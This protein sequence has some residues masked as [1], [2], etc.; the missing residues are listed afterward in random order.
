MTAAVAELPGLAGLRDD[1]LAERHECGD[2]ATREAILAE[3]ERRDAREDRARQA[4]QRHIAQRQDWESAAY[5]Q[6]RR[7]EDHCRGYLLSEA[8]RRRGREPWPML[9][10]GGEAE[11]R[12]L[13]SEE[14]VTF[15]D[16]HEPRV[17]GPAVF[18]AARREA[19]ERP[20][21]DRPAEPIPAVAAGSASRPEPASPPP[22][23]SAAALREALAA[24]QARRA[25]VLADARARAEAVNAA[26]PVPAALARP[27]TVA[28]PPGGE[29]VPVCKGIDGTELLGYVRA[30]LARYAVFPSEPALDAVTLWAAHAHAR[31]PQGK[32]VFE[33][34]G[35][36]MFLSAD[37]DSGKSRAL[38]LVSLLTGSRFGLLAEPT[39]AAV[40]GIVGEHAEVAYLD[41]S[42]LLFGSGARR[43]TIRSLLNAG[44]QRDGHMPLV[45]GGKVHPRPV[46]GPVALAGLDAMETGTGDRLR[47]LFTRSVVI[48]MRP[49]EERVPPVDTAG[50]N[51]ASLLHQA[52]TA[53]CAAVRNRLTDARPDLPGHLLNRSIDIWL[54]L[55]AIGDAAGGEWPER[56]RR[57]RARQLRQ[58]LV[59]GQHP[60]RRQIAARQRRRPLVLGPP[61][62]PR[63]PQRPLLARARRGRVHGK[64]RPT[65]RRTQLAGRLA[66]RP[67]E[68]PLLHRRSV[69]T[70]EPAQL[71]GD[72]QRPGHVNHP[73]RQR[74]GRQRQPLQRHR[75]VQQP[76]G[77]P[78]RRGQCGGDLSVGVLCHMGVPGRFLGQPPVYQLTHGRQLQPRRPGRQPA[79]GTQYPDQLIVA[80]PAQARRCHVACLPGQHHTWR[81]LIGHPTSGEPAVVTPGMGPQPGQLL[82][83]GWLG[84]GRQVLVQQR[85]RQVGQPPTVPLRRTRV[86]I[87]SQAGQFRHGWR[88]TAAGR[89]QG[90]NLGIQLRVLARPGRR[91][92]RPNPGQQRLPQPVT[93]R[94]RP[95]RPPGSACRCG[96]LAH[97]PRYW[98]ST[99]LIR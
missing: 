39:A 96:H 41:E 75:L 56:A 79:P 46:F 54:P 77:G 7:A 78:A 83:P 64:H 85:P 17:A 2:D 49:A 95:A 35:R 28:V 33:Y 73:G 92:R 12:K 57:A 29:L 55:V 89:L 23:S 11:A 81:Q 4:R 76:P 68:E 45:S 13:A 21:D 31:D 40:A 87:G 43:A 60:G 15:W 58:V 24:S 94:G 65:R 26:R 18:A 71:V 50:R 84:G 66:S 61:L 52:L 42:D 19:A 59:S 67:R 91:G 98:V 5:A 8:G 6:Y 99:R 82:R 93:Y 27:G 14:L 88:R 70:V 16:W 86:R 34:S 20:E 74:P 3:C 10:M 80:A 32:L 53:W 72:H 30:F 22:P 38:T 63:L 97:L 90:G 47:P 44:Y 48:R 62:H 25:V 1:E 51:M 69:R 9:W 36:L 37:P